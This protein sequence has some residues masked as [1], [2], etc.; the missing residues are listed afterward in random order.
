[1]ET[2]IYLKAYG[3]INL[4]L[5]IF[6]TLPGGYHEVKMIMQQVSIYDGV[7][8]RFS[9][10][11]EHIIHSDCRWLPCDERNLAWKAAVAFGEATDRK[12]PVQIDI[13]KYIPV[14]AGMAGGSSDAAAVLHGLNRLFG[15]G[16]SVQELCEIGKSIGSD[17]PFCV[18]GGTM[19]AT[20]RGEILSPL[21]A[22]P[23]C[24]ILLAKPRINV[25]TPMAYG[26]F[27]QATHV[28]HPDTDRCIEA[29]RS[30]SLPDLAAHM[31]NVFEDVLTLRDVDKLKEIMVE[32]GAIC[33]A[34]SGSGP[35]VFGLYNSEDKALAAKGK[36]R[37]IAPFTFCCTPVNRRKSF[38]V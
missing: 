19:L 15:A 14:S 20:G 5:D 24:Y 32:N 29:L 18:M 1:M 10:G 38:D 23:D 16:L 31:H 12:R 4:T 7:S 28:T 3:K 6:G 34:M 27:D 36:C 2:P 11:K 30:G 33:A 35:T 17:V 21:P 25:S 22:M 37:S 9:A 8:I 13:K 26:R